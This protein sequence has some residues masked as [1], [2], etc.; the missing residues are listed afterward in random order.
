MQYQQTGRHHGFTLLELIISLS[1][2]MVLVTVAIPSFSNLISRN[3]Q[4][5]LLKK[6]FVHHQLARSEAIKSN[7]Q[8]LLCKSD[9]GIACTAESQ[10]H[11]G[12][13]I[14]TDR[15]NNKQLDDSEQL[16]H[17][18]QALSESVQLVYR[19]FGSRNYT[20]Y[21]PGGMSSNNGSFTV[22]SKQGNIPDKKLV[23]SRTGRIRFETITESSSVTCD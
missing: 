3:Q 18:Q 11:E 13:I 22:C 2:F 20:R 10:W 23:I 15:N 16:V 9:N 7:Q 6:L 1:V 14:F 21:F 19:G 5:I 8:M 12:W 17:R 4:D